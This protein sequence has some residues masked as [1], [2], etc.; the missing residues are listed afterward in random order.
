MEEDGREKGEE[1]REGQERT[2]W[3]R[4]RVGSRDDEGIRRRGV[5]KE[6][7]KTYRQKYKDRLSEGSTADHLCFCDLVLSTNRCCLSFKMVTL[8]C[9]GVLYQEK[10]RH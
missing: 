4:G 2:E 8:K 7:G 10:I 9:T 6:E 1:T 5:E 3:R